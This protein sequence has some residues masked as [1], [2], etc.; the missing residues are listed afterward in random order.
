[1][2]IR[3]L[4]TA[5]PACCSPADS[6]QDVARLMAARHCGEIP[7]CDGTKL[8]GVITDRDIAL[9]V[10]AAGRAPASVEAQEVM[11]P[12]VYTI[13]TKDSIEDALD[14]METN[15]V[16]RLPVLDE[17][18]TV[19]GIVSQT[20]LIAK[21]PTLKIARAMRSVAQKTRRA[22]SPRFAL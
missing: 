10:V 5:D 13:R 3:N 8:V 9:R 12:E 11:T 22:P 4:M 16:R 1:M 18:D 6:I 15:L 2:E 21:S 20:D 17:R 19:V 7:V 14:V